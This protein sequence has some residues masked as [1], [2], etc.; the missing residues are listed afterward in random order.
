[1]RLCVSS[2]SPHVCAAA[3]GA[4][5]VVL[6]TLP[7]TSHFKHALGQRHV[8]T[9]MQRAA[10]ELCRNTGMQAHHIAGVARAAVLLARV[11]GVGMRRRAWSWASAA[12]KALSY[13]QTALHAYAQ[14]ASSGA[15]PPS[16]LAEHAQAWQQ[17]QLLQR[18]PAEA[19][20]PVAPES[21]PVPADGA[22]TL[23]VL[24]AAA[25]PQ[26]KGQSF[27]APSRHALGARLLSAQTMPLGLVRKGARKVVKACLGG[28]FEGGRLGHIVI[29]KA[30]QGAIGWEALRFK[31]FDASVSS[32]V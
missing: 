18:A 6:Q 22:L 26:R 20:D 29:K 17:Q 23:H 21:L 31:D 27:R 16:D 5:D 28:T 30:L 8:R 32:G 15:A 24:H 3:L 1:M 13:D 10:E 2:T 25:G 14:Q 4:R 11:R 19:A 7:A 12:F 9:D